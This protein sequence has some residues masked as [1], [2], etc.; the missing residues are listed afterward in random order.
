MRRVGVSFYLLLC[1][2]PQTT[3][4]VTAEAPAS[5]GSTG[6]GWGLQGTHIFMA[7]A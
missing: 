4:D 6:R 1:R 2:D 3:R 7:I 5:A